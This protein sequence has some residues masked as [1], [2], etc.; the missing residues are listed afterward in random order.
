MSRWPSTA[1]PDAQPLE[2][3]QRAP[4]I[5]GP[6]GID[7]DLAVGDRGEADE[8]ADLDVIGTDGVGRAAERTSAFD[9]VDVGAD[10][11]DLGAHGHQRPGEILDVG[12]AGGIAEH[13]AA[14][15][16]D[17]RHQRVLRPG[18]ARLVEE[19]V[20]ADQ[21]LLGLELVAV[22]RP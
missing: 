13:G 15:G 19:D 5:V 20:R 6:H 18:D 1:R 16:R 8:A 10:A 17:R 7:G 22:A 14:L 2:T 4:E 11:V 21:P 3:Q 9:G 12:L